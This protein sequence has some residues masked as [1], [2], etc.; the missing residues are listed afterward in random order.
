MRIVAEVGARER[1]E[2]LSK[3]EK[4]IVERNGVSSVQGRLE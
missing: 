1:K 4:G 3:R 2:E